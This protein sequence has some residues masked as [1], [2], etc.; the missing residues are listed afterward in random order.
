MGY[1]Q[2]YINQ[3][4]DASQY[5]DLLM[6]KIKAYNERNDAFLLI[7]AADTHKSLP[8]HFTSLKMEDYQML[9]D[10]INPIRGPRMHFYIET[11]GGSGEAAEEIVKLTR[12]NFEHVTFVIAGE[13]KSAGTIIA[14]SGSE[15][16]MTDSGSLGP[17]DAQMQIGRSQ[18]SAH[19]YMKWMK[20]KQKEYEKK[21]KIH[22]MDA[23]MIAQIS[24]GELQGVETS[25]NYAQ[26]LVK[27][28]LPKYKFAS[29]YT[30]ETRGEEVTQDMK[31]RRAK[32][33]AEKLSDHSHWRTHGRSLKID[34][35][36][37]IGLQIQR[38]DTDPEN[39][40]LVYQIQ[41]LI[42]VIFLKSDT[43]YKMLVTHE[44]KLFE[45]LKVTN[46]P[47]NNNLQVQQ[48]AQAAEINVK[49]NKC[50][51]GKKL[52]TMKEDNQDVRRHF[53]VQ[54]VG[55]FPKEGNVSC[56]NCQ[57]VLELDSIRSQLQKQF[58]AIL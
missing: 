13:A 48:K 56:D 53:E 10:L 44:N 2:D 26:D 33:I 55:E 3:F 14:L 54:G 51:A 38:I 36:R 43:M 50:G 31:E 32:E 28:W 7:Y 11:L 40:E 57:A 22:P 30:T 17:I 15:I 24:P 35:L 16:A 58:N 49:C 46:P 20:D 27:Q 47:A 6:N 1:I 45:H 25:L 19:A 34:D 21:G 12:R 18:I 23:I 52:F 39:A 5:V 42:K 4:P 37:S 8:S 9:F 41:A 29:W